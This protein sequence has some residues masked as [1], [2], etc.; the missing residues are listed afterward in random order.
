MVG[1]TVAPCHLLRF[2][3]TG[4]LFKEFIQKKYERKD[5]Y[6]REINLGFIQ[7]FH[8]FLLGEKKMGQKKLLHQTFK[9]LKEVAK[10]S[11]R[12]LLYILQS[13]KCL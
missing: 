12:Q 4:R 6:L 10:F 11:C 7:G 5:L 13:C 2:E 1:K 3:Y 9:V 8:A